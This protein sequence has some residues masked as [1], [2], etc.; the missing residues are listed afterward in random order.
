MCG[1]CAERPS[2][3]LRLPWKTMDGNEVLAV[4]IHAA[5]Q[6]PR[7]LKIPGGTPEP[8]GPSRPHPATPPAD[9]M[10]PLSAPPYLIIVLHTQTNRR[11]ARL[12]TTQSLTPLKTR[13]SPPLQ[14]M[15][16]ASSLEGPRSVWILDSFTIASRRRPTVCSLSYLSCN[17]H[18]RVL[19]HTLPSTARIGITRSRF[20][21]PGKA[22]RI[23]LL[24]RFP[25]SWSSAPSRR[26][27]AGYVVR[28]VYRSSLELSSSSI[29][30]IHF[31]QFAEFEKRAC[32]RMHATL[33]P[34]P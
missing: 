33:N 5:A 12:T 14:Q 29:V 3:S 7:D 21:S 23:I 27:T 17:P 2:S 16:P 24:R 13:I 22:V 11:K 34:V 15:W 28:S 30:Q 4:A 8:P 19:R 26:P 20:R 1:V 10:P 18:V 31:D 25:A 32:V 9:I 6:K